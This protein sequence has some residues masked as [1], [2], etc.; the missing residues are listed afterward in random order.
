[1]EIAE[2]VVGQDLVE[3]EGAVSDRHGLAPHARSVALTV[4]GTNLASSMRT[5]EV[6]ASRNTVPSP[7]PS[8]FV[9]EGGVRPRQSK[10]GVRVGHQ[11]AT[12]KI[13]SGRFGLPSGRS[14][15]LRGTAR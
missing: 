3:A 8:T 11:K 1:M 4:T 5:G 15:R 7:S 14:V 9:G 10:S 12:V 13:V 6:T 2:E